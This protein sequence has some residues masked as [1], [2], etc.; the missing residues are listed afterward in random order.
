VSAP[1]SDDIRGAEFRLAK[2]GYDPDHVDQLLDRL[3]LALDAGEPCG[4]I[5]DAAKLGSARR[6][7]ERTDVDALLDRLAP[8]RMRPA[9]TPV[10]ESKGPFGFLR[11]D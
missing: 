9:G 11:R 3:V 5:I 8:G 1:T 4:A 7:Y 2:S 10:A 6:G